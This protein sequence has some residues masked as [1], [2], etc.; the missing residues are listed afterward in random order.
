MYVEFKIY[1]ALRSCGSVVENDTIVQLSNT[2]GFCRSFKQAPQWFEL[3]FFSNG[4]EGGILDQG[5]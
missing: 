2:L 3:V 4:S 5:S 1:A